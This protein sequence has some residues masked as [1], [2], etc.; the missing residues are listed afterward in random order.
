MASD[1]GFDGAPRR[2]AWPPAY[3]V[4]CST[5]TTC[6]VPLPRR[7]LSA[8][9]RAANERTWHGLDDVAGDEFDSRRRV[10]RSRSPWCPRLCCWPDRAEHLVSGVAGDV[11]L[12]LPPSSSLSDQCSRTVAESVCWVAG[13]PA[14]TAAAARVRL[15]GPS[16]PA[17]ARARSM[18]RVLVVGFLELP[19]ASGRPSRG[20]VG[21]WRPGRRS[22]RPHQADPGLGFERVEAATFCEQMGFLA[23]QC[24]A[25]APIDPARPVRLPGE[26]AAR[27]LEQCRVAGVPVS[28]ETV[29]ALRDWAGRLGVDAAILN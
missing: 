15:Q 2:I 17:P 22:Q 8:S 25:N 14:H 26:Q 7:R 21:A 6:R 10:P 4:T 29:T 19:S 12:S 9:V 3:T 23:D 20:L 1:P 24:H 27:T 5:R 16:R 28:P 18:P 13:F 11:A